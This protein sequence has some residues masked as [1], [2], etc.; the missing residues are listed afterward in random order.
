VLIS[1]AISFSIIFTCS[2]ASLAKKE[3]YPKVNCHEIELDYGNRL[4]LWERAA[5]IEY[6]SNLLAEQKQE[7][8]HFS[9]EMQCFCQNEK[10]NGES[11]NKVY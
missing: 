3:K 5:V 10:K 1:L 8:T 2:K 4:D 7:E 6:K 9:G 11:K